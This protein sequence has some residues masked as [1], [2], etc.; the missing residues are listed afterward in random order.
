MGGFDIN[1]ANGM[2]M[3]GGI[4]GFDTF[5]NSFGVDDHPY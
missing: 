3:V 2:L 4:G 1:P 5:G